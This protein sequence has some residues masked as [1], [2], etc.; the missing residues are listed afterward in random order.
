[1][2]NAVRKLSRKQ[3]A[4]SEST[5]YVDTAFHESDCTDNLERQL[6]A[7]IEV[8]AHIYGADKLVLKAGKLEALGLMK[9]QRLEDRVIALQRIVF[10]DPTLDEL[11]AD[12]D[13]M[14]IIGEIENE[15]A[16]ILARREVEDRLER[17][18]VERM[19]KK[20]R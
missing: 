9:S 7:L 14:A 3:E 6:S 2:G 4:D 16:E 17:R 13:V 19:Q 8:L 10:E 18:V 5:S 15:V 11:P 20:Q 1:M 12:K